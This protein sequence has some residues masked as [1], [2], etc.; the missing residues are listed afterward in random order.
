VAVVGYDDMPVAAC[1]SLP[2]ASTHQPVALAG[3]A[4]VEALLV[5]LAGGSAAPRTLAVHLVP[6]DSAP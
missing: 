5:Q 2:L 6:R 3:Q 1:S 4:N